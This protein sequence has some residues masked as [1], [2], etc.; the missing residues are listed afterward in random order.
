ME[1]WVWTNKK[2]KIPRSL[3][4]AAG[5]VWHGLLQL[6]AGMTCNVEVVFGSKW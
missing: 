5:K 2:R 3:V 1:D 6:E 4:C